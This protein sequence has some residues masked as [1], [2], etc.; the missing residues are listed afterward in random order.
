[1]ITSWSES[2]TEKVCL[3]SMTTGPG[4]ATST[5]PSVSDYLKEK[6]SRDAKKRITMATILTGDDEKILAILTVVLMRPRT[7]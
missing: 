5:A 1:M 2:E 6:K 7:S 4:A 3:P